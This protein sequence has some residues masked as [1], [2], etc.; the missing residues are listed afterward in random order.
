VI[1]YEIIDNY[2][3][4]HDAN[5]IADA[6]LG[7]NFN[8]MFPWYYNNGVV[9]PDDRTLSIHHHQFIHNFL[10]DMGALS[11]A[12]EL[13]QPILNSI[14]VEG[15][16]RIKGNLNPVTSTRI[17]YPWHTDFDDCGSSSPKTA[18]Y[19]LN[20]NNGVTMFEDGT[21][22]K[23]VANRM[24]IFNQNTPH[25]GTTCTDQKV[26]SLINFNYIPFVNKTL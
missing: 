24:L 7:E 21:E 20:T 10:T 8:A 18:I 12:I 5:D 19:Y 25:T 9:S 26:R 16:Q 13:L 4:E 1:Q 15:W 6:M 2:L 14:K 23:S 3:P 22:I 17:V 11:P